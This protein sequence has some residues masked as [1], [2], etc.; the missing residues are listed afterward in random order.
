MKPPVRAALM[1]AFLFPG[2][3]HIHLKRIARG[4]IFLLPTLIAAI[5]FLS[6]TMDQANQIAAQILAGTMPLDPTL[7]AAKVE[8]SAA[9][10]PMM[11]ASVY[12]LVV[13]WA[14][15]IL[16]ALWMLKDER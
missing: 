9:D 14:A 11:T 5:I 7:I 15:S 6:G 8:S 16:D 10:T 13:C 3:G 12:V 2:V 4:C 1:N